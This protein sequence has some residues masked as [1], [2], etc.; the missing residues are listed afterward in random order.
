MR[1]IGKGL[2]RTAAM[3]VLA[4][5]GI[6]GGCNRVQQTM[7]INSDPPG[8]LVYLNLQEVGRTPL[9]RDFVWYGDYDVRLRLEGYETLKT[10]ER[11]IAPWWN[12]VP[13]DLVAN[14]LPLPLKDNRTFTYTLK[15][16]DPSKDDPAGLMK[17]ADYLKGKLESSEFTR[18]PTTRNAP[19]TGPTT[20]PSTAT[21]RPTPTTTGKP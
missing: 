21:T 18:E 17:R 14:V 5:G 6:G 12:W 10:H 19:A 13:F 9:N 16:L 20:R 7:Q 1:T 4:V 8:A 2:S 15:P 11:V 3:A